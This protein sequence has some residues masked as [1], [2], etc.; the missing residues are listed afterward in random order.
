MWPHNPTYIHIQYYM[1]SEFSNIS[2]V[3]VTIIKCSVNQSLYLMLKHHKMPPPTK[4]SSQK[5]QCHYGY[6]HDFVSIKIANLGTWILIIVGLAIL[7]PTFHPII[8][9]ID[10][11]FCHDVLYSE[12]TIKHKH[13]KFPCPNSPSYAS[14]YPLICI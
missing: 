14:V 8:H 6:I 1:V 2:K 4:L 7:R 10:F 5:T 9:I 13:A 12:T 3:Y 11:I